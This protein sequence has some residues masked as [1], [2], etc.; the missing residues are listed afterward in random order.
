MQSSNNVRLIEQIISAWQRNDLSLLDEWVPAD[1][2]SGIKKDT[3]AIYSLAI[4]R[5][6]KSLDVTSGNTIQFERLLELNDETLGRTVESIS[7]TEEVRKKI[8][9][10]CTLY[11]EIRMKYSLQAARTENHPDLETGFKET[12]EHLRRLKTVY[13]SQEKTEPQES[14]YFKRHIAFGIPSVIGSYHE[15]KFDALAEAFRLEEK[16]RL[17]LED[18]ILQV[19]KTGEA[20]GPGTIRSWIVCLESIHELFILHELENFQ[21]SEVLVILKTNSLYLSQVNDLLKIWQKELTWMVEL[22]HRTFRKPLTDLLMKYPRED[23]PDFLQRLGADDE[24]FIDKVV[25][26]TLRDIISSITGFEELDRLLNSLI[27]KFSSLVESGKD[28][29]T[30]DPGVMERKNWFLLSDLSPAKASILAPLL[31]SKA[32]NLVYLRDRDI[33]VPQGTV[34]PSD[35]TGDYRNYVS[36]PE[37]KLALREAAGAIERDTGLSFGSRAAPLFLAVRSGSYISMPGIL[38]TVLYCGMNSDTIEG[39]IDA[40]GDPWIASDSY[41]RF[42]EHYAEVVLGVET[43]MFEQIQDEILKLNQAKE[44]QELDTGG[45]QELVDRYLR[46]LEAGGL[47]IPESPY[48]QLEQS[49]QA[50]YRSWFSDRAVQFRKAMSVSEHWGTSVTLMNMISGNRRGSGAAVFSTRI[51]GSF[52]QGIYGEIREAGTGD[53]L[54]YGRFINRPLSR[55]QTSNSDSLEDRDPKLFRAYNE[56]SGRVEDAMGNLPPE[57]ESAFVMEGGRKLIYILQT[58]RMESRS[59]SIKKFHDSCRIESSIIGRGIG[60]HGGALSGIATFKASADHIRNLKE[61]SRQ[62]VILLRRETSTDDVSV[63]LVINGIITSIGGATSHA[64]ILSQKFDIIAV[65]GCTDMKIL[66]DDQNVTYAI[67]GDDE[68]REGTSISIDGSTGL[69]YSGTCFLTVKDRRYL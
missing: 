47:R 2:I 18:M 16:V 57:V 31:G 7:T 64:A 26:I 24:G 52:K 44:L 46:R 51:P 50:I 23:L 65:V 53:D 55:Q 36:G 1:I 69:V 15:P 49:V 62:P 63:M 8:T 14:F 56:I 60:V 38:S 68:V 4:G 5:L 27:K 41:R 19:E 54:V 42:I 33:L 45:M 35:M 59:A 30:P 37:F 29:R 21:I 6:F 10:L 40:T 66:V 12:L 34:F 28:F 61:N 48:E 3:L 58:K 43:L 17:L 20:A 25:D 13:T 9:L 32:K 11:R 22:C 67:I 39:F